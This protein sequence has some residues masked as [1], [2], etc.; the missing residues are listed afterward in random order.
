MN[1][2]NKYF[3]E[4]TK[5]IPNPNLPEVTMDHIETAANKFKNRPSVKLVTN[6]FSYA[7]E[8]F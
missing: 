6:I 2:F 7:K 5:E 1:I 8:T 3:C 4:T